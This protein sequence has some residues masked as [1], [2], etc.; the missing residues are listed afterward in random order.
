MRNYLSDLSLFAAYCESSWAE[1]VEEPP[2]FQPS[3]VATPTIT[4]YRAHLQTVVGLAPATINRH[5]VSIKRYFAW[6][7]DS[8]LIA[9]DP[10]RVVKLVPRVS[11]PPRQ[12]CDQEE[13]SLIAA[14]SE[15]GT[16]RDRV[17]MVVALHTG[18]RAEQLCGLRREHVNLWKRS[19]QLEIYGKRN[20][21]RTV[22]LNSTAREALGGYLKHDLAKGC[23]FLFPSQKRR[24]GSEQAF[25]PISERQLGY[26]VARYARIAG[27]EHLSPHDLRH[28]FGYRMARSVPL[29]RLAQIMGHDSLDTTTIYVKG[30]RAD[31]QAAVEEIAWAYSAREGEAYL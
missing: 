25:R 10:A 13:N 17:L 6:A 3:C 4:Q 14:V 16:P 19:G 5:L 1:G 8:E 9:R 23:E 22:P 7:V 29:H 2:P 31:L 30:T 18:L 11:H 26:I 12:L 28:R 21:H 24:A 20:K 27:V 15:H